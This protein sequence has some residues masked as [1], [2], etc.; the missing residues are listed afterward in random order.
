MGTIHPVEMDA[1]ALI[2]PVPAGDLHLPRWRA[3]IGES[4]RVPL[5]SLLRLSASN[6]AFPRFRSSGSVEPHRIASVHQ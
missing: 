6:P 2:E 5:A 1:E 3:Y 4:L